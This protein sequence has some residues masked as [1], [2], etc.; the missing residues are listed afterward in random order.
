VKY[1]LGSCIP[2]DDILHSDVMITA[3]KTSNQ[4]VNVDMLLTQGPVAFS[5]Q[6]GA[7]TLALWTSNGDIRQGPAEGASPDADNLQL[8]ATRST[9]GTSLLQF[10]SSNLL[11]R[12]TTGGQSSTSYTD[13]GK[14]S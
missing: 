8:K 1:E 2:E 6:E 4:G 14:S 7:E 10:P 3:V 11:T 9:G 13:M 12:A 5:M